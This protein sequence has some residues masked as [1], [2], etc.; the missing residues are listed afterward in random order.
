MPVS[1]KIIKYLEDHKIAFEIVPHK[2]VYT[3]YDLAQTLGHKLDHIVKSLL[4]KI[5]F[6]VA[7]KA[8]NGHYVI[9]LPASYK[10][11]LEKL[12][13]KIKAK[14]ISFVNEA[15]MK[16]LKIKIGSIT[17]FAT[18]K[19][20]GLI[21]DKSLLKAK[22]VLVGVESYTDSARIKIKDL[23]KHEAAL[24]AD[25]AKKNKLKLQAKAKK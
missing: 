18:L 25:F 2:K 11:D 3:A 1:K 6:P 8:K 22:H 17:P 9:I 16:L 21:A 12:A 4:V 14:K 10:A 23:L 13:K 24:I 5:E 20:F 19:K 7:E 15:K